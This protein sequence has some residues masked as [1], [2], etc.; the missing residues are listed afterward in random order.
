MIGRILLWFG[1]LGILT[2]TIGGI[3]GFIM[4]IWGLKIGY[5]KYIIN[6]YE[7]SIELIEADKRRDAEFQQLK[8]TLNEVQGSLNIFTE[9]VFDSITILSDISRK[10]D[11]KINNLIYQ[12]NNLKQ[13]MID[14]ANTTEELRDLVKI[15][16][17]VL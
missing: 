16:D 12:N 7:Q 15:W 11:D 2:K 13:Y 6:K 10:S 3:I 9:R 17:P 1:K 5:D 8:G 4:L 14:N